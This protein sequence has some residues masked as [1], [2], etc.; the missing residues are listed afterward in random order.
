MSKEAKW[1]TS[2]LLALLPAFSASPA[3]ACD[4]CF[5]DQKID[6][7]LVFIRH[8]HGPAFAVV[9]ETTPGTFEVELDTYRPE[10]PWLEHSC[11][12]VLQVD[13]DCRVAGNRDLRC[14]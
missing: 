10:E 4:C 9:Y 14:G 8:H 1:L 12:G 7:V 11:K 5:A 3:H 2:A 6:A 13:D